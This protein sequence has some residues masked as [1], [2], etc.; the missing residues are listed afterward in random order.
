MLVTPL[1]LLRMGIEFLVSQFGLATL[2][3]GVGTLMTAGL[4]LWWGFKLKAI[5]GVAAAI[6]RTVA[7]HGLV[8]LL[9]STVLLLA[10]LWTGIIPGIDFQTALN[11]LG[12]L[13]DGFIGVVT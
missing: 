3:I 12:G 9:I 7:R 13:V 10:M 4:W 8:S 11:V 6:G 5:L 2:G 1:D